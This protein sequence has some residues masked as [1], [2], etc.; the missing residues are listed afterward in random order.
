MRGHVFSV[1]SSSLSVASG[2]THA[3]EAEVGLRREIDDLTGIAEDRAVQP[4]CILG[5]YKREGL[6]A[7]ARGLGEEATD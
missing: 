4:R 1:S 6:I 2:S 5:Q 7:L 3:I